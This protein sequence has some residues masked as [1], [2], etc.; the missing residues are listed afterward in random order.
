MLTMDLCGG[1]VPMSANHVNRE[2]VVPSDLWFNS[3]LLDEVLT[4]FHFLKPFKFEGM[5]IRGGWG[6][7][8]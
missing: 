6:T 5:Q 3:K 8:S 4:L 2:Q 1:G 7:F